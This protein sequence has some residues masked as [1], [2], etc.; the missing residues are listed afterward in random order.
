MACLLSFAKSS[1]HSVDD[2][3]CCPDRPRNARR[4]LDNGSEAGQPAALSP[5]GSANESGGVQGGVVT[6]QPDGGPAPAW[7]TDW[8]GS[9]R[10]SED[11]KSVVRERGEGRGGA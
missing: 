7:R 5:S 2:G 9:G 10:P 4:L 8:T 1:S 3:R 11:R 6:E